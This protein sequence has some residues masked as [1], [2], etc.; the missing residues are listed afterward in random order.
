MIPF[1][2]QFFLIMILVSGA[3]AFIGDWVGRYFGR[4]RL[5]VFSLRPRYTAILITVISGILI[6]FITLTTIILISNDARTAL[7]GLEKLRAEVQEN[8]KDLLESKLE[9]QKAKLELNIKVKELEAS[10]SEIKKLQQTKARLKS[11]VEIAR[12]GAILFAAGEDIYTTLI[13]AGKP[14]EP[15]KSR[16]QKILESL[17]K[18]LKKFEVEEIEVSRANFNNVAQEISGFSGSAI[19]KIISAKNVTLG[20]NLPV[21]LH[22]T[23]NGLVYKKGEILHYKEIDGRLDLAGI[24]QELKEMLLVS[25]AK[26]RKVGVLPDVTGSI[27]SISYSEIFEAAK[28]IKAKN[29]KVRVEI[30]ASKDIYNIGPLEIKFRIRS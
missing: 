26:A 18:Y 14:L 6:A 2:L 25:R 23:E 9:L 24:E 5:T 28:K 3:I 11:E 1:S 30:L 8:Q 15:T 16:I 7:F 27:G 13:E 19:L 10:K 4:K 22:A 20:Q 21:Y 12:T 17:D 29:K